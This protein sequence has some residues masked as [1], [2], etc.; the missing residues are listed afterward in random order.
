[1]KNIII[2]GLISTIV[3]CSSVNNDSHN[4]KNHFDFIDGQI[5]DLYNALDLEMAIEPIKVKPHRVK[6]EAIKKLSIQITNYASG[7]EI[8]DDITNK[9]DQLSIILADV[10]SYNRNSRSLNEMF[11]RE[12]KILQNEIKPNNDKYT[13]EKIKMLELAGLQELIKSIHY[14]DYKFERIEIL[15]SNNKN[16]I[17][18][19]DTLITEIF[20][21]G[22]DE[23][24]FPFITIE[25]DTLNYD[26]NLNQNRAIFKTTNYKKG[27]N[28][29]KGFY[30]IKMSYGY[31]KEYP[32][33]IVFEVK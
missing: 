29:L 23:T 18:Y 32:F 30:S 24:R 1:M 15:S 27:Q 17:Q 14:E 26:K 5:E 22:I 28:K 9:I 12:L 16:I 33:E 31:L 10:C 2:L 21:I 19:G 13:I 25:G 20:P 11:Q 7:K 8:F 6:Q 3:G 4:S